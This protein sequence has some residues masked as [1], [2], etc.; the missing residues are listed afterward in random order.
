MEKAAKT[1]IKNIC[2]HEFEKYLAL[3]DPRNGNEFFLEVL[4]LIKSFYIIFL[5]S[6]N[7]S[8][9][10]I[11]FVFIILMQSVFFLDYKALEQ[12]SKVRYISW[13]ARKDC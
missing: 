8:L 3:A 9:I 7:A 10:I 6:P 11:A 12:V 1:T 4:L 2:S 5:L 13:E